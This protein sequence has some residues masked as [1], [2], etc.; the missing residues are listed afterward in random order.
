MIPKRTGNPDHSQGAVD[1]P[2]GADRR[3][4]RS[5]RGRGGAPR[6]TCGR[7]PRRRGRRVRRRPIARRLP[8]KRR[9]ADPGATTRPGAARSGRCRDR[10]RMCIASRTCGPARRRAQRARQSSRL[11]GRAR[12][13]AGADTDRA[14][15]LR[16]ARG[17]AH[18]LPCERLAERR[19]SPRGAS[20]PAGDALGGR[21]LLQRSSLPRCP[22]RSTDAEFARSR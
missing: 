3:R 16:Q 19:L 9:Q 6:R 2:G 20:V 18:A 1:S 5:R 4:G 12:V 13:R 11:G 10:D 7:R 14:Q 21:R 15:L 17:D 22:P 8:P